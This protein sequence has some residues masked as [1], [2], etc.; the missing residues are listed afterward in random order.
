[1]KK[2]LL[3]GISLASLLAFSGAASAYDRHGYHGR[4]RGYG[5]HQYYGHKYRDHHW[6]HRHHK[7]HW[8]REHRYDR[9]YHRRHQAWHWRR[10]H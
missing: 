10:W 9:H 5:H 7:R 2:A 8:H 3:V 1:M 6:G 4:D